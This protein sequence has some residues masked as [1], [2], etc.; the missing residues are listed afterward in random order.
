MIA[1]A[2]PARV[3]ISAACN[4]LVIPPDPMPEPD[5]PL[6]VSTTLAGELHEFGVLLASVLAAEAGWRVL[7]L[8][9]SLPAG[10]I[11]RAAASS[12]AHAVAVSVVDERPATEL[13]AELGSLR[14]RL[15]ARVRLLVGGRGA[16]AQA[17]A[18]VARES[19]HDGPKEQKR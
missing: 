11:A 19:A 4:L 14:E 13:M 5:A 6:L 1:R 12:R 18:V 10:E 16:L 8:G 17:D 9:P 7:Y 15:P 3:A 2:M